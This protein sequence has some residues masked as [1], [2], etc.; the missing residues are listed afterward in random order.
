MCFFPK[1]LS[2]VL[3]LAFILNIFVSTSHFGHKLHTFNPQTGKIEHTHKHEHCK[4]DDHEDNFTPNSYLPK[5]H[6]HEDHDICGVLDS[7]FKQFL[8]SHAA[9]L[10][11]AETS[12]TPYLNKY[13]EKLYLVSDILSFAPKLSPTTYS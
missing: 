5:K 2:G 13:A 10:V 12:A 7:L 1:K 8:K 3:I 6:Q 11:I 9:E 4:H